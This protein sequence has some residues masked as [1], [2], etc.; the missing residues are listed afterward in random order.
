MELSSNWLLTCRYWCLKYDSA[1]QIVGQLD[2]YKDPK[3]VITSC[4][5]V[6]TKDRDSIP[7]GL[8]LSRLDLIHMISWSQHILTGPFRESQCV[9]ICSAHFCSS[10]LYM[11]VAAQNVSQWVVSSSMWGQCNGWIDCQLLTFCVYL[12]HFG[13]VRHISQK[14]CCLQ[15]WKQKGMTLFEN[16]TW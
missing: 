4:L 8:R 5:W 2:W 12:I 6:K 15:D 9:K 3:K 16:L 1:D 7:S 14:D 10:N 11:E 13:I